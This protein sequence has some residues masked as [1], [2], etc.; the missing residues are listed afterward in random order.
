MAYAIRST[1]YEFQPVAYFRRR[2]AS[3]TRTG[4]KKGGECSKKRLD[5]L[6]VPINI[7]PQASRGVT[8]P[9]QGGMKREN[10]LMADGQMAERNC[11]NHPTI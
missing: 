8:M 2:T 11:V 10:G 6:V 1:Q 4:I 7:Q 3:P 5:L 9:L